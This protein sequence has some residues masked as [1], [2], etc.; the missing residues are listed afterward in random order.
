[1]EILIR[2]LFSFLVNLNE[3]NNDLQKENNDI[4]KGKI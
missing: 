3:D 1:M 2:I 4:F